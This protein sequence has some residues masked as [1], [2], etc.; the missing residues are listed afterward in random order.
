LW[1]SDLYTDNVYNSKDDK[2]SDLC[3]CDARRLVDGPRIGHK[4]L[5]IDS[6]NISGGLASAGRTAL[7]Q[8]S[9]ILFYGAISNCSGNS[10]QNTVNQRIE[11]ASV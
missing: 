9:D 7:P 11:A 8:V 6:A 4:L 10:S 1:I 3:F 2:E 5:K